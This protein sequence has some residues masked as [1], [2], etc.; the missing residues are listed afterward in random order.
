[1]ARLIVVVL[2]HVSILIWTGTTCMARDLPLENRAQQPSESRDVRNSL[3][4]DVVLAR[5]EALELQVQ[6]HVNA[7]FYYFLLTF[8]VLIFLCNTLPWP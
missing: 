6:A 5:L 7:S 1:M 8:S 4:I 2:L 3:T